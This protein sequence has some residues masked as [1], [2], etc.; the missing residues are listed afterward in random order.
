MIPKI[1]FSLVAL[2]G[3]VVLGY[4][5]LDLYEKNK[6]KDTIISGLEGSI[7]QNNELIKSLEV[8]VEKYKKQAP[9]IKEKIITKYKTIKAK[10]TEC[11]NQIKAI[12]ESV[13]AFFNR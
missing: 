13:S 1:D 6:L 11:E 2:I 10:D 4:I 7:K 9:I 12:D 8:D 3:L 5:T